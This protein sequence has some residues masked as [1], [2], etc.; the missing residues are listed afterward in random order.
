MVRQMLAATGVAVNLVL[1]IGDADATEFH[2]QYAVGDGLTGDW[3]FSGT[4][5]E[6]GYAPEA[7]SWSFGPVASLGLLRGDLD[8]YKRAGIADL[9]LTV[10][11]QRRDPLVG[12]LGVRGA[13]KV[14]SRLGPIFSR[15]SLT[16]EH[17]FRAN[18]H[19]VVTGLAGGGKN[20]Y[21]EVGSEVDV[22]KLDA[23][24]AMHMSQAVTGYLDYGGQ[25]DLD[26][27]TDHEVALRLK[28]S[29]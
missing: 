20:G 14:D 22:M 21:Y 19:L 7:G 3:L 4:D 28:F 29:F 27:G 24:F 26:A 8:G 9:P 15:L 12:S 16:F 2:A 13:A 1:C 10:G 11:G 6:T 25:T 17:E 23:A 5:I 18:D